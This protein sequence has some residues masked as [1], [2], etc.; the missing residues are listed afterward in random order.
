MILEKKKKFLLNIILLT[1]TYI[2]QKVAMNFLM[3]YKLGMLQ[4][5]A[6][7]SYYKEQ[8]R[9]E[10]MM[11]YQLFYTAKDFNIFY[12]TAC[13]A[14]IHMNPGMFVAAF[15]TAVIYRDD[16]K[17]L[18]LPIVSEIYPNMFFDFKVIS[19]TSRV[20]LT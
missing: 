12:Q 11:L 9:E 19:Q 4:K 14:R 17:M 20:L 1:F 5:D 3:N 13:W 8:H 18:R 7:F 16:C 10:M 15:T 6:L 2:L